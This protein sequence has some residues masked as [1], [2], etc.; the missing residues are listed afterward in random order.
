MLNERIQEIFDFT[1]SES[2][3]R[4]ANKGWINKDIFLDLTPS[5]EKFSQNNEAAKVTL[6]W[7]PINTLLSNIFFVVLI[8]CILVF[9]SLSFVKGRF[10]FNQLKTSMINNIVIDVD[11]RVLKSNQL[12]FSDSKGSE[13]EYKLDRNEEGLSNEINLSDDNKINL[14]KKIMNNKIEKD[15]EMKKD[16]EG[17]NEVKNSKNQKPKSNFI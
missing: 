13:I 12:K 6:F 7:S 15:V 8:A 2:P 5:A 1:K 10:N 9:T 14:D 16:I 4:K 11:E 17:E 3:Y